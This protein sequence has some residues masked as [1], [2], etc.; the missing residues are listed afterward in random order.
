[1]SKSCNLCISEIYH[2]IFNP[3]DAT[4]NSR[5]EIK[6]HCRHWQTFKLSNFKTW[7]ISFS[8]ICYVFKDHHMSYCSVCS[9]V[10]IGQDIFLAMKQFVVWI[11]TF[12]WKQLFIYLFITR[13]IWCTYCTIKGIRDFKSVLV[14]LSNYVYS[15]CHFL[16][17][18][19]YLWMY[20]PFGVWLQFF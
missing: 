9:S 19:V 3:N 4:L 16:H 2:I 8:I 15:I 17:A 12:C 13:I 1:M 7:N 6:G 5:N 10:R 14:T 18:H 11:N 20:S